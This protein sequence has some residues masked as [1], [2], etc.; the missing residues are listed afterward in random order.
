MSQDD[1][2]DLSYTPFEAGPIIPGY[3]PHPYHR[4][5]LVRVHDGDTAWFQVHF[6]AGISAEIPVRT[7]GFNSP[8]LSG[9]HHD[10]AVKATEAFTELLNS[11]QIWVRLTGGVTFARRVGNVTVIIDGKPVDVAAKLTEMGFN[12]T[13][14]Q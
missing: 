14:G 4:A 6:E 1:A 13:Q 9:P 3:D 5:D 11:G 8:E 7:E 2:S 12:V 10:Q